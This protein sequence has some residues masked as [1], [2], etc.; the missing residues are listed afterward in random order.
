MLKKDLERI[1]EDC[2]YE[3]NL[4]N[5]EERISNFLSFAHK[6]KEI[7]TLK[8]NLNNHRTPA[9]Q[10]NLEKVDN[11]K[12]EILELSDYFR[13]QFDTQ[14]VLNQ[15]RIKNS[16]IEELLSNKGLNKRKVHNHNIT[17]QVYNRYSKYK[18]AVTEHLDKGGEL[19]DYVITVQSGKGNNERLQKVINELNQQ[20]L[21][22]VSKSQSSS[23][24]SPYYYEMV[25]ITN[26]VHAN[27]IIQNLK[28]EGASN[29]SLDFKTIFLMPNPSNI[30]T[31]DK[32]L[33]YGIK[34]FHPENI[35]KKANFA[36]NKNV[37]AFR[38]ENYINPQRQFAGVTSKGLQFT[39]QGKDI[40]Q[41]NAYIVKN[42]LESV[43]RDSKESQKN[44]R[45]L[46]L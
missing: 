5:N 7:K 46:S 2:H 6:L 41:N 3:N 26:S 33:E 4:L 28:K 43:I 27:K 45:K 13:I 23:N 18:E 29:N 31:K 32:V 34:E 14:D 17:K 21:G 9:N 42:P 40:T 11:L 24:A 10:K 20:G 35:S 22:I 25:M 15:S 36:L 12:N 39:I 30:L 38:K 19:Y 44:N 16:D 37:L 1:Y 8:D